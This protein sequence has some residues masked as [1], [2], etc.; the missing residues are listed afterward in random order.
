MKPSYFYNGNPQIGKTSSFNWDGPLPFH[1]CQRLITK[2]QAIHEIVSLVQ[3]N[4]TKSIN[5]MKSTY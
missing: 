5:G 4:F 3:I 1:D 2:A